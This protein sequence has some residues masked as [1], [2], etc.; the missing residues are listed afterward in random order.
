M[1]PIQ[2]NIHTVVNVFDSFVV[3]VFMR[4]CCFPKENSQAGR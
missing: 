2:D 4:I 1:F 3:D